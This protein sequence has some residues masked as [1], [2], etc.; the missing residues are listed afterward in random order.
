MVGADKCRIFHHMESQV[1]LEGGFQTPA[2]TT[3][4][5]DETV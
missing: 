5:E 1:Y 2:A 3:N 4:P